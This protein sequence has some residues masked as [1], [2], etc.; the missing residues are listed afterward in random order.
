LR[1][2]VHYIGK[3]RDP[4]LNAAAAEYA[5][6]LGRFC[7]FSLREIKSERDA[8]ETKALRVALDPRGEMLDSAGFASLVEG[9]GR[10]IA[11]YLG[12][13]DGWSDEFRRGADRLLSLSPMTLPHEL[14]RVVLVE[15]IYRAFTI[16]S[17]HPYNK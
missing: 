6:R 5:K 7:R 4:A 2:E 3:P 15:Q 8:P 14:A 1:I 10:D 9:A 16:L 17:G 12:G 13:A 11:F